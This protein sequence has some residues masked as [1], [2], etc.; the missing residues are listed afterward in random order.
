VLLLAYLLLLDLCCCQV[1]EN[2]DFVAGYSVWT[3]DQVTATVHVEAPQPGMPD[4]RG[5]FA[6]SIT[7]PGMILST[8]LCH[9]YT[10]GLH[11]KQN[12]WQ[13]VKR[14]AVPFLC[15]KLSAAGSA[16]RTLTFCL[17]L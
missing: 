14:G 17:T 10:D 11:F 4:Q 8:A 6:L 16:S 5:T 3:R 15:G 9:K 2:G 13:N 7:P 1:W 12:Y